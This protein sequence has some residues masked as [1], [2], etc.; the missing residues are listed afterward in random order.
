MTICEPCFSFY[1]HTVEKTDV[2]KQLR[3]RNAL[4]NQSFISMYNKG[5]VRACS[6]GN[7]NHRKSP[8]KKC[9][10]IAT[11]LLYAGLPILSLGQPDL[12]LKIRGAP[13]SQQH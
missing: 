13:I 9:Q 12:E 1:L 2:T 10:M 5:S 4:F 6:T 11:G 3:D 7:F 8:R